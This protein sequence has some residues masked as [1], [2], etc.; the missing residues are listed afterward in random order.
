MSLLS[1]LISLTHPFWINI[2]I[3]KKRIDP[4]LLTTN[5]SKKNS[6]NHT[7]CLRDKV[8]QTEDENHQKKTITQLQCERSRAEP[9]AEFK[10]GENENEAPWSC[11]MEYLRHHWISAPTVETHAGAKNNTTALIPDRTHTKYSKSGGIW[12][13]NGKIWQNRMQVI[14]FLHAEGQ[15]VLLAEYCIRDDSKRHDVIK[16]IY[17]SHKGVV[18]PKMK[19]VTSRAV[20]FCL[21]L[22]GWLADH[23]PEGLPLPYIISNAY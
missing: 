19:P 13:E 23:S 17:F 22:E 1:H 7:A 12:T 15:C 4:K 3:F 20:V 2:F 5:G 11:T 18:H 6:M 14:P 10:P 21:S 9:E 8:S 16:K